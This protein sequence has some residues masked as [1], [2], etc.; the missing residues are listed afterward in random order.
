MADTS[1]N[2]PENTDAT[3]P[4]GQE[5]IYPGNDSQQTVAEQ[6]G[7]GA[8]TRGLDPNAMH[9]HSAAKGDEDYINGDMHKDDSVQKPEQDKL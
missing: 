9:L 2:T 7:P 4:N 8:Q 6:R 5:A 1:Q 3:Q